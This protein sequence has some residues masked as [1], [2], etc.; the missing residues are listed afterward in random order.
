MQPAL[1]AAR[2]IC[3]RSVVPL[4]QRAPRS[5]AACKR[6]TAA[7]KHAA[8]G[9][10]RSRQLPKWHPGVGLRERNSRFLTRVTED[11]LTW[12][13]LAQ[14]EEARVETPS[15]A[16]SSGVCNELLPRLGS[17]RAWLSPQSYAHN[18][19]T[20]LRCSASYAAAAHARAG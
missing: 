9:A 15:Y 16:D 14:E 12:H 2:S 19:F 18:L 17:R 13:W 3:N 7:K 20:N 4:A 8:A 5:S 10:P 11:E 1:S 6:V